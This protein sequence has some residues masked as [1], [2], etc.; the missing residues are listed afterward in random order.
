M[1]MAAAGFADVGPR[2]AQPLVLGGRRQHPLEQLPVAGHELGVV[3][4]LSSHVADPTGQRVA[5]GLQFAEAE[6]ARRG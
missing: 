3:L 2:D 6:G 5:D 1:P 4:K